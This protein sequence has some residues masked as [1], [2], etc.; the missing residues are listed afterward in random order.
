MA[1]AASLARR[2][3]GTTSALPMNSVAAPAINQPGGLS[4]G[5]IFLKL[6][7]TGQGGLMMNRQGARQVDKQVV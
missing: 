2:F 3:A 4:S 1:A 7:S 5:Q 6:T